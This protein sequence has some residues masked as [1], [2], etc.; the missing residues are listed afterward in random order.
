MKTF[1]AKP[2]SVVKKWW[3]VDAAD[4]TLGRLASRLALILQG[5]H[6]PIYTPHIDTGDFIIVLNAEKI[7]ISGKK[8]D[9]KVYYRHSGYPGGQKATVLSDLLRK[10]P[11]RVIRH[12]VKGMLPKNRLG[13]AQLKKLK[14]YTGTEHPHS[15]QMPQVLTVQKKERG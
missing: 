9:Q 10:N 15:A 6:K 8:L 11:D 2:S 3:V 7:G 1:S 4:Q 14:I 12:A 5:K 13:R